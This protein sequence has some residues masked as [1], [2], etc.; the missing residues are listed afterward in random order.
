MIFNAS[1]WPHR[2][3]LKLIDEYR[4]TGG[5]WTDGGAPVNTACGHWFDPHPDFANGGLVAMA[6]YEHGV[7]LLKVTSQGEIEETGYFVPVDGSTSAAYW[8]T[9][10]I[11]Y[12]TDYN[13][14][15]I[16]ILHVTGADS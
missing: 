9:D 14:R 2:G 11:V 8:V 10:D 7:R 16:D 12:S 15:G 13:A 6:W 4:V 3:A 5:I 1:H